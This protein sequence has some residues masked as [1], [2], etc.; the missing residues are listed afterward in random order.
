MTRSVILFV[1]LT[2]VACTADGNGGATPASPTPALESAVTGSGTCAYSAEPTSFAFEFEGGTGEVSVTVTGTTDTQ[3]RCT[4]W[5]ESATLSNDWVSVDGA[6]DGNG[7]IDA[8]NGVVSVAANGT[9]QFSIPNGAN[10]KFNGGT[11]PSPDGGASCFAFDATDYTMTPTNAEFPYAGGTGDVSME[12]SPPVA[13]EGEIIIREQDTNTELFTIS[14]T[15]GGPV[16]GW[17]LKASLNDDAWI[18]VDDSDV[19]TFG[20]GAGSYSI[21]AGDIPAGSVIPRNGFVEAF[22]EVNDDLVGQISIEQTL[23][24]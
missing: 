9:L 10:L 24:R 13:R 14:I 18:L 12:V 19:P 6:V 22:A 1:A 16:C 20:D 17:Y 3:D 2:T 23:D 8:V 15:Q 11:I 21:A 4:W 5:A 7:V